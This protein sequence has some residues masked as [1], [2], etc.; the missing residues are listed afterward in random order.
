MLTDK[1]PRKKGTS[2]RQ[3]LWEGYDHVVGL[4]ETA[5]R[6]D[7]ECAESHIHHSWSALQGTR[8][9]PDARG[10]KGVSS[11][12]DDEHHGEGTRDPAACRQL[13]RSP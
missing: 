7:R 13:Y 2:G 6:I 8:K 9:R 11:H 12:G 5:V 10:I 4:H 3:E 1:D